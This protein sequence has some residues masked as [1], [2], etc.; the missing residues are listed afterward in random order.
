MSFNLAFSILGGLA[1][2]VISAL[3]RETG[4]PVNAAY[5][6]IFCAAMSFGAALFMHNYD[7][8]ILADLADT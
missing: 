5:Y 2:L 6:M 7:G 1:P 3:A 8:R 4:N